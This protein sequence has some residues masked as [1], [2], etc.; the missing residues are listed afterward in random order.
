M[1]KFKLW[2]MTGALALFMTVS[3]ASTVVAAEE[4]ASAKSNVVIEDEEWNAETAAEPVILNNV[5]AKELIVEGG[6]ENV[7]KINGGNIDTV[8]V[9]APKLEKIGYEE[10]VTMLKLGMPAE[11]VA[12]MYQNFLKERKA[13][14]GLNPTIKVAGDA[15]VGAMVVSGG[16]N[17]NMAGGEI[18][19]IIVNNDNNAERITITI[20]NYNGKV[21]VDQKTN[22]DKTTNQLTIKL[23][24]S[25]LSE[26]NV[27]GQKDCSCSIQ[28]DKASDIAAVNV[29]G[30][31]SMVLNVKATDLVVEK[32]AEKSYVAVYNEVEN[33]VLNADNCEFSVTIDAKVTNATIEGDNVK[34]RYTG[35]IA[36]T[37]I[38]GKGADVKYAKITP[39]PRPT[40]T[41]KPTKAPKPTEAPAPE[42]TIIGN[43]DCSTPWWTAFS[44]TIH[45]EEGKTEKVTFWNYTN[46]QANWNNFIII[47]KDEAR[48]KEYAVMRADNW[49]WLNADAA[50][51]IP[52]S[53]KE[54]AWNW[55]TF[56]SDMNGAKVELS[57]TNKGTTVDVKADITTKSG[58]SYYQNYVDLAIDGE[59]DF[60]LSVEGGYLIMDER[61]DSGD[62][63][64][65]TEEPEETEKTILG[66]EDCS[67]PWWTVFTDG[68]MVEA[69]TSEK[70]TF[71]NYTNGLANWNNFLVV[72]KNVPGAWTET[73]GYKEYAVARADN[74][75]WG[76]IDGAWVDSFPAEKKESN[77]NWDTYATDMN[78]ATVELTVT[79]S[80]ST[81]EI[82]AN[83]TTAGGKE[84]FQKYT[85][86][87]VDGDLY[88]CLTVEGGYLVF[89]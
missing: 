4:T 77:W 18:K 20:Q 14:N 34:V 50:N 89:E 83:I 29:S 6:T 60:C 46:G 81:A 39:I 3:S 25:N 11:E 53:N 30:A 41:P 82:L 69:G 49:G 38:N 64:S 57:V 88:Y 87:T 32:S 27:I 42:G 54:S 55:D 80:G 33:V 66:N 71:K 16:A 68:I 17:L 63:D 59:V 78:G 79:N 9:V 51:A 67:T 22:A 65:E 43:E 1:K 52:D 21:K 86:I 19:E 70:I 58:K 74:H 35:T 45:V 31:A 5:T 76:M 40:S 12:E 2:A 37:E 23:V 36:N 47:L 44:D 15:V 8:S 28:G 62:G 75:G 85:G 48:A 7:L 26:L 24:N 13:V 72:L 73:N 61:E 84:Y 56:S 10:I